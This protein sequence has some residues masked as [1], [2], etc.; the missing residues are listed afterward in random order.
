[1]GPHFTPGDH[2]G[3]QCDYRLVFAVPASVQDVPDLAAVAD[4]DTDLGEETQAMKDIRG[5]AEGDDAAGRR[6]TTAQR[7]RDTRDLLLA[8]QK[9]H[10]TNGGTN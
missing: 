3:C 9:R 4:V 5:L 2:D 7:E 1:V 8:L 6:G 10:L